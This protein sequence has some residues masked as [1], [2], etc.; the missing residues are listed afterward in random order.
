MY[1]HPRRYS[2]TAIATALLS[3]FTPVQLNALRYPDPDPEYDSDEEEVQVEGSPLLH[4]AV[5]Q[6][7]VALVRALLAAGMDISLK[8]RYQRTPLA[9]ACTGHVNT[10]FEVA[11]RERSIEEVLADC[12]T[13]FDVLDAL[14]EYGADPFASEGKSRSLF[15]AGGCSRPILVHLLRRWLP[16]SLR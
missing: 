10:C 3:R 14:I 9:V 5:S 4:Y 15:L 8:D 13:S 16:P 7:P 11:C 1:F 2:V 12:K 6:G